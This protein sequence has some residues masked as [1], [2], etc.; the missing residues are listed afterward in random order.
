MA[1]TP[2][3]TTWLGFHKLNPDAS[4]RLFC[5]PY[6]GAAA[7]VY[8]EWPKYLPSSIEVCAIQL[9]GKGHRMHE[10]S[11]T[12]L[13]QLVRVAATHLL[14][15]LDR[16][17]AFFGHS[18]GASI[19]FELAHLLREEHGLEPEHLF[20]SGRSAP[21]LPAATRIT[22][23]LPKDEFPAELSHLNGTPREVL[24]NQTFIRLM[25]PVLRADFELI[26]T[27]TYMPKRPLDCPI[28]V[29]GGMLDTEVGL[30]KLEPWREH[31][32]AK[33]SLFMLPGDHFFLHTSRLRLLKAISE[34]LAQTAGGAIP[35]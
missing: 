11:F 32:I 1:I 10:K 24:E 7:V 28:T 26:E 13:Q 27:Y 35:H 34:G 15:I 14:P 17:F 16:P 30:E 2:A 5:F 33:F 21:Q 29:F 12:N 20:I 9:P 18:M 22:Y 8:R 25:M 4:L 19:V 6:A 31:T 3:T 23:N